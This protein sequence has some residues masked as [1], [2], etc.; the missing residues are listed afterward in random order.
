MTVPLWDEFAPAEMDPSKA[1]YAL[2][3]SILSGLV[4]R[5]LTQYVYDSPTGTMVLVPDIA[6]DLGT[7]NEDFTE[8]TFTIRD[9]VRFE[10]GSTVTADDVAYGIMRSFD[11]AAF[12]DNPEYNVD[13]FLDGDTYQGPYLSGTDFAGVVVDGEMLTLKMAK[14]FPDLPYYASFPQLGPIPQDG[15]DP[16]TYG[17][18]PLATGPYK[19]GEFAVG[20][21]LTLVR[22]DE[23]DPATDAGR[24]QYPDR[25]V[26]PF[27][28]PLERTIATIL[29]DSPAG[30]TM[31]SPGTHLSG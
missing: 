31:V 27:F 11:P 8:W 20:K 24:H 29:G 30:G 15:S 25:Y 9:G 19:F 18:H 4:T 17:E 10:D 26:F 14:P 3:N 7:P 1:Y 23:W 2:I 5:S 12:P 13:Y 21:S 22:N 16:D 6:T 28:I